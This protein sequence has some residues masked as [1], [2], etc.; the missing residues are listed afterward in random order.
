MLPM[1]KDINAILHQVVNYCLDR[2][3]VDMGGTEQT[4][5][6]CVNTVPQ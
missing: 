1:P 3:L 4:I 5:M 2:S 6:L